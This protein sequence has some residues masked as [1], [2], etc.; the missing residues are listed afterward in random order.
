MR[1]I[2]AGLF[3]SLDGV[4]EAPERWHFPYANPEMN[5]AVEATGAAADTLLLGRKTYEVFVDF[6]PR[7]QGEMADQINKSEKFVVTSTL[8]EVD[9][10]WNAA[11]LEGD[12][13][14]AV[15]TLKKRE[16]MNINVVGSITLVRALLRAKVL[17]ELRLLIHPIAVGSGMRLF[18]EGESQTLKLASSTTFSNGVVYSIYQ[19]N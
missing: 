14:D 12:V 2:T 10:S 13:I 9:A 16:G 4:V 19:P 3:V 15:T 6:W 5:E 1:K 18:D 7:L 8:H 11:I 17:D